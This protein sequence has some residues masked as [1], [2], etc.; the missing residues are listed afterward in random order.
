[1]VRGAFLTIL[2]LSWLA[3]PLI[4]GSLL[5]EG[6]NYALVYFV[7]GLSL[8]LFVL[9]VL[10]TFAVP[11]HSE[12]KEVVA[13]I[14]IGKVLRSLWQERSTHE[15][16]LHNILAIN[17]ILNFFYAF[18]VIYT[19]LYLHTNIGLS[20]SAIGVIFTI[21]LLPF[22][23]L[24]Y[25]LGKL[26]DGQLGEKEI[27]SAGLLIM[28]LACITLSF[29]TSANM[30]L[31]A[32]VLF[33]SRLGAASVE[34][35]QETYLFKKINADDTFILA[36]SRILLPAAYIAGPLTATIFL[37]FLPIQYLFIFLGLIV[38]FGLRYALV[39]VDT[40]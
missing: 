14:S 17:F 37:F 24:Q 8:F 26:A 36:I 5:G 30:A 4:I 39:L 38:L 18:M 28:G 25:P 32:L 7:S 3:S 1:V 2:N 13:A 15:S 35:A 27:L 23:F 40:K 12:Q 9:T 29:I 11:P 6:S 34:I 16:D 33:V 21:M 10:I 22:V 19:P 31:W 20:W